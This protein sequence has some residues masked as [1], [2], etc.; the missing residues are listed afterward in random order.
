M[1]KV[2]LLTLMVSLLRLT[3][4]I[5]LMA[6]G[7]M[8]CERAGIMNLGAEGMMIAGAFGAVVGTYF[9]ENPWLGVLAA[10]LCSMIVSGTHSLISVEFGGIQNISGLGLNMLSAGLTS[11]LC[12]SI[13]NTG[14]SPSVA[15][16]QMT[17]VF[18]NIPVIGHFL[19]QF[20]PLAYISVAVI[21]VSWFIMSKTVLGMHIV[22]VGDD[23]KAAETA[24][25]NV[26]RLRHF[27]VTVLC[28]ALA[29]LAGAYLS[30]GQ[31]SFFMEDM[32]A[33]KGMLAVIAVKMGRWNTK[34]VVAMALLFGFFDA[35]QAQLQINN[36]LH[37]APELIQ[38]IPYLA[39]IITILLSSRSKDN[40]LALRVPYVKNKYKI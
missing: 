12:R 25:I 36:I 39:G 26:W 24:G 20:S 9:T 3:V 23:P 21:F 30:I 34:Y 38:T 22:A 33:G 13:F 10:I 1:S 2:I 32:T 19:Y 29:G 18:K 4:P 37:I 7:N 35:L 6:F 14:I 28:G 17:G 15:S 8:F 16:I 11:F 40:P 5:M 27:C 31:L